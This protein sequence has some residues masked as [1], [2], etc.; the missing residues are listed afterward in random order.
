[1]YSLKDAKCV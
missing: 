1:M